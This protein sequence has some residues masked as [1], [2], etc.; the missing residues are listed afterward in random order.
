MKVPVR[1]AVVFAALLLVTQA[2]LHGQ[3]AV[4]FNGNPALELTSE[5]GTPRI[6]LGLD[7]NGYPALVFSAAHFHVIG[8]CSGMIKVSYKF[9]DFNSSADHRRYAGRIPSAHG[10]SVNWEKDKKG[11]ERL[12]MR[13]EGQTDR[14]ALAVTNV[15]GKSFAPF[16]LTGELAKLRTWFDDAVADFDEAYYQFRKLT[17]RVR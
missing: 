10:G 9:V 2:F 5:E 4:V 12:V 11:R 13:K 1:N 16:V 3:T 8:E 7:Q 6:V 17:E 14:F 15:K